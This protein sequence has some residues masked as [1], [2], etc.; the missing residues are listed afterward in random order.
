MPRLPIPRHLLS[1]RNLL[2][3]AV[4]S[5]VLIPFTLALWWTNGIPSTSITLPSSWIGPGSQAK[6]KAQ[7]VPIATLETLGYTGA[8]DAADRYPANV[9]PPERIEELRG[10]PWAGGWGVPGINPGL[11]C[12]GHGRYAVAEE[13][14]YDET[15]SS[16]QDGV[17]V[18]VDDD[19]STEEEDALFEVQL[20]DGRQAGSNESDDFETTTDERSLIEPTLHP[21]DL[22]SKRWR[23]SLSPSSSGPSP[24]HAAFLLLHFFSTPSHKPAARARRDLIRR[25]IF[26]SIPR[27]LRRFIDVKFVLAHAWD[28][29]LSQVIDKEEALYR[30]LVRLGVPDP[31]DEGGR[32]LGVRWLDWLSEK[33]EEVGGGRMEEAGQREGVWVVKCSDDVSVWLLFFGYQSY[34]SLTQRAGQKTVFV[35]GRD[36]YGFCCN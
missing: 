23:G 21:T 15:T 9:R 6:V 34:A 19:S 2:P 24:P 26:T 29:A 1:P 18:D 28:P 35:L 20:D 5:A 8:P 31:K 4:L 16:G 36:A 25:T 14:G 33:T 30:D 13:S 32:G 22:R 10:A 3:F 12:K 11:D 17:G 27:P 7:A